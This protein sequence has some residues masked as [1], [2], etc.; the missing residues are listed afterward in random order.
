MGKIPG[1]G[2]IPASPKDIQQPSEAKKPAEAAQAPKAP[3]TAA[4]PAG[5]ASDRF[6]RAAAST[7]ANPAIVPQ[8]PPKLK[9]ITP[10]FT[11]ADYAYL[12]Q[13]FAGV[14]KKQPN[15]SRAERARLIAAI[16]LKRSRL[17]KL[18]AAGLTESQVEEMA[19]AIGDVLSDSTVFGDLIDEVTKGA[20]KL[21]A[22]G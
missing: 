16:I 22:G 4:A 13:L 20:H 12:A 18:L 3:A 1:G 21:N 14:L 8:L 17:R 15:A 5:I 7:Q 6:E 19:S 10:Q 11:N 9:D 2:N